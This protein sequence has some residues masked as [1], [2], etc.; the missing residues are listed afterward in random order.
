MHHLGKKSKSTD[1]KVVACDIYKNFC[2]GLDMT[3]NRVG[4]TCWSET[5]AASGAVLPSRLWCA[6]NVSIS[7][8]MSLL[9]VFFMDRQGV[10]PQNNRVVGL[11]GAS[12]DHPVR[13]PAKAGSH[14]A[15]C[16][17]SVQAGFDHFLWRTLH[18][19]SEQV[20][21]ALCQAFPQYSFQNIHN[22][23]NFIHQIACNKHKGFD[24]IFLFLNLSGC[25]RELCIRFWS[26]EAKQDQHVKW[27]GRDDSEQKTKIW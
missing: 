24:A 26:M 21:E 15:S 9:T 11:E 12:G 18:K 5:T 4:V 6:G 8:V 23:Y 2:Q 7:T 1:T 3:L 19:L 20:V 25:Q 17:G 27:L 13:P 22:D 10:I 14:R 16:M